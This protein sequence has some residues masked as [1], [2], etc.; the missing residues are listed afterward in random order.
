MEKRID[1]AKLGKIAGGAD[2]I[3]PKDGDHTGGSSGSL[4]TAPSPG[5]QQQPDSQGSTSGNSNVSG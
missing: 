1:D 4:G 5:G 2:H 3:A